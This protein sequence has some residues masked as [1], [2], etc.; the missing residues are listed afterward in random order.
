MG[1]LL[2]CLI[3]LGKILLVLLTVILLILLLLL[4]APFRYQVHGTKD[5]D[6]VDGLATVT[7]LF[8]FF[9]FSYLIHKEGEEELK[10]ETDLRILGLS[11]RNIKKERAQ[12]KKEKQKEDK[13]KRIGRLKKQDPDK[14]RQLKAEAL[15]Q[16]EA[17]AQERQKEAEAE[18]RRREAERLEEQAAEERAERKKLILKHRKRRISYWLRGILKGLVRLAQGALTVLLHL[19]QLPALISQKA[20][21][22]F[23]G[24]GKTA[25]K[26]GLWINFLTDSRVWAATG[27]TIKDVGKLL[28][29]VKPKS[30]KGQVTYGL[31]DPAATGQVL[32]AASAICP[33]YGPDFLLNPDFTQKCL[34]GKADL[35]GSFRLW[36]IVYILLGLLLNRNVRYTVKFLKNRREE[37]D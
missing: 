1:I 21:A 17:R 33:V 14:Y 6:Q 7:W 3:L 26:A 4:F 5:G 11:P 36:Y 32:A 31:E 28:R 9:S 29:H 2:T 35:T 24:L 19:S 10:K 27:L 8:H 37:E 13:K 15:A 30:L 16:R 34:E 22:F 20:A 23:M 25:A 18:A 12:R